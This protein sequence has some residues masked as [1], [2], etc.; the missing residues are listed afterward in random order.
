MRNLEKIFGEERWKEISKLEINPLEITIY[1]SIILKK[2][3]DINPI[4]LTHTNLPTL[5][6]GEGEIID[7]KFVSDEDYVVGDYFWDTIDYTNIIFTDLMPTNDL[8]DIILITKNEVF[9]LLNVSIDFDENRIFY[10]EAVLI[11]E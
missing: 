3:G 5:V 7:S 10:D 1:N 4:Y 6:D 2:N 9:E 8:G 11:N